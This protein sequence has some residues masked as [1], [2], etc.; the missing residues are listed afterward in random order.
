MVNQADIPS[1][2]EFLQN[3]KQLTVS[4]E[5]NKVFGTPKVFGTGSYGWNIKYEISN[6]ICSYTVHSGKTQI[7]VGGKLLPVQLTGNFIVIGSKGKK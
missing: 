3:A 2:A 1:S 7:M 4:V 5:D 6:F